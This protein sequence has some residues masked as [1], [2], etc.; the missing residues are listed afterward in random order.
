MFKEKN[1]EYNDYC[2][3]HVRLGDYL[4]HPNIHPI[5]S[6]EYYV[7]SIDFI[8]NKLGT[9]VKFILFSDDI[10]VAKKYKCF[11]DKNII[12]FN[13]NSPYSALYSMSS[14]SDG[15][16]ANSSF[17][18]W[19]AYFNSNVDKIVCYPSL[20]FGEKANIDT[21]DL[22]PSEWTKIQV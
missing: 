10:D 4:L 11:N 12:P 14:C 18:W 6:E 21:T 2:F 3:I 22:C 7:K 15:I 5:C 1:I 9:N 17:S 16:I 19:G 8:K 20:W 13:S